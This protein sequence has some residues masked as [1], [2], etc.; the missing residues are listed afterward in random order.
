MSNAVIMAQ[1]GAIDTSFTLLNKFIDICPDEIWAEKSGGWAVWQQVYHCVSA[2]KFFTGLNEGIPALADE[3]VA[4]L[5]KVAETTVGKDQVK[6]ALSAAQATA[7]KYIASL[8]DAD[9][10]ARNQSV[11]AAIEWDIT[12]AFTLSMI[13]AH[14]LYHLGGCDAALRNRGLAGAF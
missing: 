8:T 9:L 7:E 3:D 5:S 14:N 11:Y 13:A 6:K 1:K 4:G 12:H 2:V 10:T